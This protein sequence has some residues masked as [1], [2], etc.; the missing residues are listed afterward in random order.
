MLLL[1]L[2]GT[3]GVRFMDHL[4]LCCSIS[5]KFVSSSAQGKREYLEGSTRS[6]QLR[7]VAANLNFFNRFLIKSGK[8]VCRGGGGWIQ[9]CDDFKTSLPL[10]F[11]TTTPPHLIPSKTTAFKNPFPSPSSPFSLPLKVLSSL[12]LPLTSSEIQLVRSPR[13]DEG[14]IY[15]YLWSE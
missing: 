3:T 10:S 14:E 6:C 2:E 4:F 12:Y 5:V 9:S 7:F 1:K 15:V 8:K 11:T 13:G